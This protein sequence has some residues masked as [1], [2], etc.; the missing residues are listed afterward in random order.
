MVVAFERR[1]SDAA[2]VPAPRPSIE[3]S[4]RAAMESARQAVRVASEV[5]EQTSNRTDRSTRLTVLT[6]GLRDASKLHVSTS[7]SL[8]DATRA[9]L[10]AAPRPRSA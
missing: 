8:I 7:R 2:R 10:D 4:L 6:A 3:S 1:L 5:F 9:R